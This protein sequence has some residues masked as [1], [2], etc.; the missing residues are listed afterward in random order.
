MRRLACLLLLVGLLTVPTRRTAAWNELGHM[1]VAK[2]AYDQMSDG[3]KLRI[4]NTL[5]AHPHYEE[6]LAKNCPEG[7]G[8][9]EWVLLRASIWPDWIRHRRDKETRG[10]RV[11]KYSR[12]DDHYV[13][14][15]FIDPTRLAL[16]KDLKPELDK[17]DILGAYGQRLSELNLREASLEDKA[18]ALCWL[19]HLIGDVHQPLHCATFYSA[20]FPQGDRGGTRFGLS[21]G[22][23]RHQLHK[24]WDELLGDVPGK[25]DDAAPRQAKLYQRIAE[26]AQSLRALEYSRELLTELTEN[27]TFP[28]WV[29]ESHQWAVTVGYRNGTLKGLPTDKDGNAPAEAPEAGNDY[30]TTARALARKRAALAG[31]RLADKLKELK[32]SKD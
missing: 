9:Q 23:K 6:Y 1:V 13:N 10:E 32:L 30:E 8:I 17:H 4:F 16:L 20:Q 28:S 25:D 26:S 29:R 24:F 7:V 22:G 11:T 14:L 15:P 19:F 2:V 18:V 12:P 27:P 5:K 31:H 21:V 3:L